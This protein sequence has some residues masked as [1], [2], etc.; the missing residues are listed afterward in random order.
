MRLILLLALLLVSCSKEHTILEQQDTIDS[1]PKFSSLGIPIPEGT[2][3]SQNCKIDGYVKNIGF[4]ECIIFPV[5]D[6]QRNGDYEPEQKKIG[7]PIGLHIGAL[8]YK[9]GKRNQT[10]IWFEKP[11]DEECNK[12]LLLLNWYYAEL[13]DA[14]HAIKNNDLTNIQNNSMI[15]IQAKNMAC[16]DQRLIK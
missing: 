6:K 10:H 5:S 2:Q 4:S 7:K 13:D 11:I 1:P 12:R 14:K 16:G 15:L 9:L 8:G 3:Y